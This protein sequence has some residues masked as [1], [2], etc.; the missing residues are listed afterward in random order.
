M[1]VNKF[2]SSGNKSKS[3]VTKK[4][5]DSKFINLTNNLQSKVN[6]SGDTLSGILDMRNHKITNLADPDSDNDACNK[7]YVNSKLELESTLTK[8]YVD[9]L[10]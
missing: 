3:A 7:K 10:N 5:L 4:D 6:K 8:V 9:T 2:G 1:S